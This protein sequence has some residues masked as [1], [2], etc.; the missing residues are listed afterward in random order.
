MTLP[1]LSK[2]QYPHSK[3]TYPSITSL[4]A[5]F[6]SPTRI[7]GNRSEE[8]GS[9]NWDWIAPFQ[10]K[11]GGQEPK[12]G[13][14]NWRRAAQRARYFNSN[15]ILADSVYDR[16]SYSARMAETFLRSTSSYDELP[17]RQW[18]SI[19]SRMSIPETYVNQAGSPQ[20][21]PFTCHLKD[22]A[23]LVRMA[24]FIRFWEKIRIGSRILNISRFS[25]NVPSFIW[26]WIIPGFWALILWKR[27][28]SP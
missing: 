18:A 25:R 17:W 28:L 22:T 12:A 2:W 6:L 14:K 13:A 3:P 5:N 10:L 9:S 20:A 11:C 26:K 4:V 27:C 15:N 7:N 1:H 23:A 24:A 8:T 19:R 21:F 16:L